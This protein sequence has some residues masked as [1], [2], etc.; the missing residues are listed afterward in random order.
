MW[1]LKLKPNKTKKSKIIKAIESDTKSIRQFQSQ[2]EFFTSRVSLGEFDLPRL[3]KH[4]K[5][6]NEGMPVWQAEITTLTLGLKTHQKRLAKQ[7]THLALLNE[8]DKILSKLYKL[9]EKER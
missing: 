7:E 3:K 9:D 1:R 4:I 2:I 8:K 5:E 6:I